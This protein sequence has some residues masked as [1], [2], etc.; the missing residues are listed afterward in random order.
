MDRKQ[1]A[2]TRTKPE[3][4]GINQ[5]FFVGNVQ[6]AGLLNTAP[7]NGWETVNSDKPNG[8]AD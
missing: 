5:G 6:R 7:Y 8:L 4:W 3:P 2:D 1:A